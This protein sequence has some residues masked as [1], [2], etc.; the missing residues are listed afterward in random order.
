[1]SLEYLND[2][3]WK[4]IRF[5]F[6]KKVVDA[7]K[8]EILT[9]KEYITRMTEYSSK[10]LAHFGMEKILHTVNNILQHGTEA[11]I[12][13]KIYSEEG[14]SSLNKYLVDQVDYIYND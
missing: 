3:L 10:A 5:G 4:A 2:S 1:M 14:F 11:I 6:E 13:R 12:Q 9:M 8:E 7:G